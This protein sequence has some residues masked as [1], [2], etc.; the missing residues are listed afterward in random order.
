MLDLVDVDALEE[1]LV[2][3]AA[4]GVVQAHVDRVG[5]AGQLQA[6]LQVGLG[7]VVLDLPCLNPGVEE[8][9]SA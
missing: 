3:D 4:Q 6:V 9:E 8:R 1:R 5:V 2:G 7:L